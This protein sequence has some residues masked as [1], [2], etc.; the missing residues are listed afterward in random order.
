MRSPGLFPG[1]YNNEEATG[2]NYTEDGFWLTGDIGE[3]S[4][5]GHLMLKGRV[6]EKIKKLG[7]TVYPRDVEWAVQKL[8]G[9]KEIILVGVQDE[10]QLSDTLVYFIVG[11]VTEAA[12]L[13]HCKANLPAAWRPDAIVF[14]DELPKNR[15]GKP[16]RPKLLQLAAQRLAEAAK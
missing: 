14:M 3:F 11:N 8:P 16:I 2:K 4:N 9:I 1:Y 12:V 7:Y 10:A 5:D 15:T 13:A 6:I